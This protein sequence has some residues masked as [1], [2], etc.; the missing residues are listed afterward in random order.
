MVSSARFSGFPVF[1]DFDAFPNPSHETIQSCLSVFILSS[2][3][4]GFDDENTLSA[5][6]LV[7]LAQES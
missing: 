4:L 5:D 1:L 3:F 6:P 2:V 7:A